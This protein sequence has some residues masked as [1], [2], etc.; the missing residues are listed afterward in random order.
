[1]LPELGG[2]VDQTF[3]RPKRKLLLQA[4]ADFDVNSKKAT[5]YLNRGQLMLQ[6]SHEQFI[7][8]LR[9]ILESERHENN[10]VNHHAQPTAPSEGPHIYYPLLYSTSDNQI[11][12]NLDIE[13]LK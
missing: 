3:A 7:G 1:M 13:V 9:S 11:Q 8:K 2:L 5:T 12:N 10:S 6:A 4:L